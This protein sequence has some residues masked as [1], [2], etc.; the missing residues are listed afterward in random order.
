M[1]VAAP[2]VRSM[3]DLSERYTGLHLQ[4]H[5]PAT[6][7]VEGVLAG[8]AVSM[9]AALVPAR[10]A[11]RIDI[12]TELH[13]QARRVETAPTTCYRQAAVLL[14]IGGLGLAGT[15]V[16]QR[17]GA[18]SS[19]QPAVAELGL[20]ITIVCLFRVVGKLTPLLVAAGSRLSVFRRGPARLAVANLVREP[21]RTSVLAVAV[22]AT[23]GIA[24]VLGSLIPAIGDGA[25]EFSRKSSAGRAWVSTLP[26]NNSSAID[27]K[28]SPSVEAALLRV[29]GVAGLAPLTFLPVDGGSLGPLGVLGYDGAPTEWP[30]YK[31]ER[32]AVVL[33]RGEVMVGP[34]L[35]RINHLHAGSVMHIPGRG[36]M[37]DLRVGG[38]WADPNNT[39]LGVTMTRDLQQSIW[40]PQPVGEMYVQPVAGLS[41]AALAGRITAAHLDPHLRALAPDGLATDLA[42]EIQGFMTPFWAL[43]RALLLVVFIAAASTFLLV[44]V[45]RRR[46]QGLLAAVGMAP[47]DLGRMTLV[48]AGVVGLAGTVLGALASVGTYLAMSLVAPILT[49]LRPPFHIAYAAPLI[50]GVIATAVVLAGAALPAWRTSRLDV[51]A[52]LQYE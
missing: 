25:T 21:K 29:P 7:M 46:E 50:Y 3:S 42:K 51:V 4:V 5:L 10:R 28:I 41:A 44:S 30:V 24:C 47:S 39:G 1:A 49:G 8:I 14:A 17:G 6:I 48:E 18:L 15:W 31:G 40:G 19:W 27:A 33:A 9:L 22:G 43:Q 45:Q 16:G 32:G 20:L 37:V 38:I 13:D 2:L 52:A 12:A 34:A 36:R 23:V 11:T 26:S 35:A